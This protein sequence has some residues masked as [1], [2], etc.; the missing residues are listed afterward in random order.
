MLIYAFMP[1]WDKLRS[2]HWMRCMLVG[3]NASSIGLVFTACVK[4]YAKFVRNNGEA[5]IMLMAMVLVK[6]YGWKAPFAILFCA[7]LGWCFFAA[8]FGAQTWRPPVP[9]LPTAV[10]DTPTPLFD[11]ALGGPYCHVPTYGNYAWQDPS[12]CG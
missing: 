2:K 1:F 9:A 11:A 3:M 6:A 12:K 10:T 7:A 8:D 4:L 5:V